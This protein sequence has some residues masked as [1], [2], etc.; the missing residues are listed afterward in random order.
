MKRTSTI[1]VRCGVACTL[2]LGCAGPR[3][4]EPAR[5]A[6]PPGSVISAAPMAAPSGASAWRIRYVSTGLDGKQ[7]EVTGVVIAPN[8]QSKSKPVIGYAHGTLGIAKSCAPSTRDPKFKYITGLREM[9]AH[10][11]VIAATDYPGLGSTGPHPYLVGISEGRAVLDSVRA[12]RRITG[13]S[14]SA[15]FI[16]WGY[17]QGGH[18]ALF[19]GQLARSYAPEL[20][21]AGIAAGAPPTDLHETMRFHIGQ[22]QNR[23]LAAYLLSSW[24]SV[25]HLPLEQLID[26]RAALAVRLAARSCLGTTA[27][28]VLAILHNA[29]LGTKFLNERMHKNPAWNRRFTENSPAVVKGA[30]YFVAQ[31]LTDTIVPPNDTTAYVKRACLNGNRVAYA[32]FPGLGHIAA[33]AD[34]AKSAAVW[35]AARF[36]GSPAASDCA[37]SAR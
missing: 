28:T 18:A 11:F 19:A 21:M 30:A 24:S 32:R 12:A 36:K 29:H 17:S 22:N 2:L 20:Q 25:Y 8:S 14:A 7:I 5:A 33:D 1:A 4:G 16:P 15:R 34:A 26:K 35:I 27:D 3:A 23:L 9:I 6:G 31:G 37:A 13:P 10:G